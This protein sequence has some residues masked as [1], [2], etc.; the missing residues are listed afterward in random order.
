MPIRRFRSVAEMENTVWLDRDDPRLWPTIVSV[1]DLSARLCPVRFPPGLRK[2][3]SIEEANR[4]SEEW[5]AA[6][7]L[8][9]NP[10]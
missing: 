8:R 1:W 7:V 3:R 5:E 6:N 4:Q 10:R 9:S 2:H